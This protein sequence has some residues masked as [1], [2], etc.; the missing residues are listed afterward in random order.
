MTNYL[1]VSTQTISYGEIVQTTIA[2]SSQN[3]TSV[4]AITV[5]NT[6]DKTVQVVDIKKN[7]KPADEPVNPTIS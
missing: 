4:Q 7:D 3:E 5:Y 2:L 1:P 6:T